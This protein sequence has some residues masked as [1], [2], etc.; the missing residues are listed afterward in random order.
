MN[1]NRINAPAGHRERI[2]AMRKMLTIF[3]LLALFCI[4]MSAFSGVISYGGAVTIGSKT[5]LPDDVFTVDIMLTGNDA[6]VA[7]MRIPLTISNPLVTCTS[8]D[9]SGSIIPAEFGADYSISGSS[10]EIYFTPELSAS[11]AAT[12]ATDGKLATLHLAVD[13]SA[14]EVDVTI[15]PVSVSNTFDVGG[16]TYTRYDRTEFTNGGGTDVM[17]PTF[18]SGTIAIRYTTD[19]N[20]F[21]NNLPTDYE[22][23]QNYPNPFNPITTIEFALPEKALVKLE[24][25]N[26]LGQKM[27][28]LADGEFAAGVHSVQWE[29]E[30]YSS[31]IYFYRL[32][33]GNEAITRKMAL[34]K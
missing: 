12:A 10:V 27:A 31:G 13:P 4:P 21:A 30:T 28:T 14:T 8:V 23:A 22:L 25:F 16:T 2:S 1:N 33:A 15:D 34:L 5:V 29:A 9:F 7:S 17:L 11:P 24:I 26:L 20:D 18:N 32:T 6:L 19:V 3:T